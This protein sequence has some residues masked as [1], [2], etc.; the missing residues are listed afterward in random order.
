MA[1]FLGTD[2]ALY[3]L[4]WFR[5]I[6]IG[7]NIAAPV[8]VGDASGL[9]IVN[10]AIVITAGS[11]TV[12]INP[13][14]GLKV[15]DTSQQS[16]VDLNSGRVLVDG[17]GYGHRATYGAGSID[18]M[19]NVS[20]YAGR[21][22]LWTAASSSALWLYDTGPNATCVLSCNGASS[23]LLLNGQQVVTVRQATVATITETADTTYDANE[24]NMLNNLKASVNNII[25]RL[26]AHG[27]IA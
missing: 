15:V 23:Y 18:I 9:S 25:Q 8:I 7:P 21:A 20:G 27:L 22:Y 3:Y 19:W 13:S 17:Y 2:D 5:D 11:S 26:Q 14:D 4:N 24:A 1:A 16:L 10:A 12:Y 6:R